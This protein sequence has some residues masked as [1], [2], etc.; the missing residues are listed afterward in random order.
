M[1]SWSPGGT[2]LASSAPLASSY[3][4]KEYFGSIV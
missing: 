2:L 3:P 1:L 4:S